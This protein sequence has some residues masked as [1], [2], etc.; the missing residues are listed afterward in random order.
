MPGVA[1]KILILFWFL[2]E[3]KI[4]SPC[5]PRGS[6]EF[7][8]K[9]RSFGPAFWPAIANI[10]TSKCIYERRVLFYRY[11]IFL[12]LFLKTPI[13]YKKR[14]KQVENATLKKEID[15]Q[16]STQLCKLFTIAHSD[17]KLCTL[18][19]KISISIWPITP[20]K[21]KLQKTCFSC[22]KT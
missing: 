3:K 13:L 6:Q 12:K 16:L 21:L 8:K 18:S 4:L 2:K 1:R 17:L 5:Y 7:L 10:Y 20:V 15:L 22:S 19:Y 14:N 11:K 9:I